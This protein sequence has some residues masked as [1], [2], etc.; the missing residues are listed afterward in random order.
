MCNIA[1]TIWIFRKFEKDE[2]YGKMV[3]GIRTQI[4]EYIHN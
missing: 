4:I 2:S 3:Y 1:N